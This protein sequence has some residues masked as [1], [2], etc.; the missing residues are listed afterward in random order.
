MVNQKDFNAPSV[1]NWSCEHTEYA[2]LLLLLL[3]NFSAL[4]ATV[5]ERR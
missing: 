5:K 2:L 1:N 4:A 3:N